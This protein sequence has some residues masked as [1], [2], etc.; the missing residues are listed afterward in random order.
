MPVAHRSAIS[1]G[2]VHIP[3]GLYTA[4]QD[5]DVRFN[6]LCKEDFS[7]VRYKK[8]CS[9]CGKEVRNSDIVKGFEYADGEYVVVTDEEFES[10]KTEKDKSIRIL[11]FTDLSAIPPI[12]Y[13]KTYHLLPEKGSEKAFELLRTAMRREDK[14]AVA[15]AVLGN[16]DTLLCILP[17]EEGLLLETLF[18]ADEIKELPKGY[19]KPALSEP[20]LEMA[21][22][23][24]RSM[25]RPFAP[26]AYQD[27][28]QAR[29]RE[30]IQRKIQG[31]QLKKPR[32]TREDNIIDLMEALQASLAQQEQAARPKRK[33]T[34][35]KPA[36]TAAARKNSPAKSP[37]KK[38]GA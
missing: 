23:L 1:F 15:Q 12:Y 14:V 7:R 9:G 11:H 10:V 2:L 36:K 37:A 34:P 32:E 33:T 24:I 26:S 30:L 8:V 28:Y 27:E 31:K 19:V 3:V 16:K 20:E 35:K 13:D 4:T 17:G 22:A 25:D 21:E 5:N 6:Q 18:F 38:K 29:L